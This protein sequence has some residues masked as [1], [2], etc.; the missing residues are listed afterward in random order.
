LAVVEMARSDYLSL[1][2]K[3]ASAG[4]VPAGVT[5]G[6]DTSGSKLLARYEKLEHR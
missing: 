4:L 1:P 5:P 2:E 6:F 3:A